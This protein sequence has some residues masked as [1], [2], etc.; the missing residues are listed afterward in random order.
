MYASFASAAVLSHDCDALQTR[1]FHPM[2]KLTRKSF[3]QMWTITISSIVSSN[4]AKD[5]TLR[6][7][8]DVDV[9]L[10]SKTYYGNAIENSL[11]V[12]SKSWNFVVHIEE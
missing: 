7:E 1:T 2:F 12:S 10:D 11:T 3:K 9:C 5:I 6:W 8:M 4:K